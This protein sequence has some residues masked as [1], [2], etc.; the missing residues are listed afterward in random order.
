MLPLVFMN[1]FETSN[2]ELKE[3]IRGLKMYSFL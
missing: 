2:V 1:A 3:G